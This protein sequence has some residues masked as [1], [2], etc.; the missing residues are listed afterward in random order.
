MSTQL[1]LGLYYALENKH[2]IAEMFQQFC[3]NYKTYNNWALNSIRK[4]KIHEHCFPHS[5]IT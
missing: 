2:K 3:S 1:Q 5:V 4:V